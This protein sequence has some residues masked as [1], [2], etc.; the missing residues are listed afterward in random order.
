MCSQKNFGSAI[1][2]ITILTRRAIVR[3]VRY[4]FC[5]DGLE[6]QC[7]ETRAMDLGL[8]S[9]VQFLGNRTDMPALLAASDIFLS[10]SL[11]EGMPLTVLEALNAGLPCV[12]SSIDEH[13]DIARSMPGCMFAPPNSP[14]EIAAAL[15]VMA[16]DPIS[17][18]AL[19]YLRAP[20]LEKFSID[21]CVA[22]YLSLYRLLCPG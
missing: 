3:K 6:R 22:S 10:T 7:L 18:S 14:E 5:G 13:Y 20:F 15:E 16:K 12:L 21:S 2:A 17:P 11:Y 4:L 8:D 1:D 9:F 19:K